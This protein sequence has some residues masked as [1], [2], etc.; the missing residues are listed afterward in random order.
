VKREDPQGKVDFNA[1]S[2]FAAGRKAWH[3][4]WREGNLKSQVHFT[5]LYSTEHGVSLVHLEVREEFD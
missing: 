2:R 1:E 5:D 3:G 4:I